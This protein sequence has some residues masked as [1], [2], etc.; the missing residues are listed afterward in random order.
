M[1]GWYEVVARG[2]GMKQCV[3]RL[4][5]NTAPYVSMVGI[6]ILEFIFIKIVNKKNKKILK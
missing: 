2:N 3:Q 5:G 4:H 1:F 6:E